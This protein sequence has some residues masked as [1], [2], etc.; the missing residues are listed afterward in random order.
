MLPDRSPAAGE[1]VREP[2]T[3][4]VASPNQPGRDAVEPGDRSSE[5]MPDQRDATRNTPAPA[6]QVG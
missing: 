6:G 3:G 2:L 4:D 5:Q 1:A